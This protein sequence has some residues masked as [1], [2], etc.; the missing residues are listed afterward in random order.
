M[1]KSILKPTSCGFFILLSQNA[2]PDRIRV[3]PFFVGTYAVIAYLFA[4]QPFS[5]ALCSQNAL[6]AVQ[7]VSLH[8]IISLGFS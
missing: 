6:I 5:T 4:F 8:R 2:C 3:I 7:C 1:R